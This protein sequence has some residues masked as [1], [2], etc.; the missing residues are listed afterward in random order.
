M[1]LM[2]GAWF[3]GAGSKFLTHGW[4]RRSSSSF[5]R[6]LVPS[7]RT[8][9]ARRLRSCVDRGVTKRGTACFLSRELTFSQLFNSEVGPPICFVDQCD[10]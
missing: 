4:R 1:K 6:A 3:F 8:V 2:F 9:V 5:C 7:S 10:M